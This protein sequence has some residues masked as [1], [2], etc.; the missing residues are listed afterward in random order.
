MFAARASLAFVQWQ[1]RKAREPVE[2]M[3][4]NDAKEG[5]AE[6]ERKVVTDPT[7]TI[8][9]EDVEQVVIVR[10]RSRTL[11]V[12]VDEVEQTPTSMDAP[13]VTPDLVVAAEDELDQVQWK[14]GERSD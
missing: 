9:S 14:R 13:S 4:S 10:R 11:Q 7:T 3:D 12:S 8:H 1:M 2:P 6:E 5:E